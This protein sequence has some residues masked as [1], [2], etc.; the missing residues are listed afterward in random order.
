MLGTGT[1]TAEGGRITGRTIKPYIHRVGLPQSSS[2]TTRMR[3]DACGPAETHGVFISTAE[4]LSKPRPSQLQV[5]VCEHRTTVTV[6]V[7]TEFPFLIDFA[8]KSTNSFIVPVMHSGTTIRENDYSP[9][10][11]P[12]GRIEGLRVSRLNNVALGLGPVNLSQGV[13]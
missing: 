5:S 8:G 1:L 10:L 13:L 11:A 6:V 12:T 4:V 2:A 7:F 3:S 9:N